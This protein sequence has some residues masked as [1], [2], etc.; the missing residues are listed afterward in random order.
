MNILNVL[1]KQRLIGNAAESAVCRYLKCRGYRILKRNY[2]DNGHE[3]DIICEDR[4]YICFTEVK[5]RTVKED[6]S[7]DSRPALAV[8]LKKRRSIVSAARLFA[9]IHRK[10]EKSFRFDVAEV[11]LNQKGKITQINYME[12]AFSLNDI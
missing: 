11:Y 3:I 12:G 8:T 6:L 7:N 5:A 9:A 1:T 2:V 10:S 4:N